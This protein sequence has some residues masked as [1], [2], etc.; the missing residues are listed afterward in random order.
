MTFREEK[1]DILRLVFVLSDRKLL[2]A[3]AGLFLVGLFSI[4]SASLG[5]E[6]HAGVFVVRQAIWGI[7]AFAAYTAVLKIGYV[8][9]L[10]LAYRLYGIALLLLFS[11]LILGHVS[12]GAQS[13]IGLAGLRLQPSE[14]TKVALALLLAKHL[15]RHP[16]EGLKDLAGVLALAGT[17]LILVLAQ[18]DLGSAIVLSVMIFTALYAAGTPVRYLWSL[19]GMALLTLPVA[20]HF[21][22]EYQK[23]R[24]MVFLNPYID[25]LGAGYNVIQSRIAVGSGRLLG[26]GFMMGTQSKLGFLPE[27]HT[28]FIFS[29]FAEEFGFLGSVALLVLFCF[30]LWRI[31]AAGVKARD[32]RGKILVASIA[33]WIWFQAVE[34]MAMSMGIAPVTG[35]PL[36]FL[37]YGGSSLLALGM[38]LG[39]TQSVFLENPKPDDDL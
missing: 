36:P 6:K 14:L 25:P 39:L 35:L 8:R 3:A 9:L 20:W 15:C 16:V 26:K 10:E 34:G 32:L 2:F 7:V 1:R 27:P 37:S 18:P 13:W 23:L 19:A 17:S 30:L 21:L 29:V 12:R 11:V 24:L 4:F 38:A 28:D 5:M 33:G 31:I 22:K